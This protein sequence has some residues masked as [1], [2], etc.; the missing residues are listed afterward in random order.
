MVTLIKTLMTLRGVSQADLS[1][2]TGVSVTAL[3]RYF[4]EATELRSQSFVKLLQFLGANVDDLIKKEINTVIGND[5]ASSI[6]EDIRFLLEQSS[7]IT[8]KTITDTLISSL[9]NDKNPDTR[10]RIQRLKKYKD[11]IKTVRRVTC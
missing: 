5:D 6:G 8:R 7:P 4:N 1:R 11:S 2:Q 10:N 9:K 3:S